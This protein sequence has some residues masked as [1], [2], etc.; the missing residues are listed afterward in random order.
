MPNDGVGDVTKMLRSLRRPPPRP[1]LILIFCRDL[2]RRAGKSTT[3][4]GRD[5]SDS[6]K[7]LVNKK[8]ALLIN[9]VD[10][11]DFEGSVPSRGLIQS[12]LGEL[13]ILLAITKCDRMPRLNDHDLSFLRSRYGQRVPNKLLGFH[14]VSAHTGAGMA[15]LAQRVRDADGDVVVFG[16]AGAGKSALVRS[17]AGSID[18]LNYGIAS[19]ADIEAAGSLLLIGASGGGRSAAAAAAGNGSSAAAASSSSSSAEPFYCFGDDSHVPYGI[20]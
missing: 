12:I 13:P 18:A 8:D 11:A 16:G 7:K 20:H 10:A 5:K 19:E 6:L 3:G 9:V 15:R 1:S 14:G 2:S 17:L 4:K